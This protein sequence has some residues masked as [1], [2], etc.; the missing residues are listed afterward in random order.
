MERTHGQL[1]TR[2]TNGLRSHDADGLGHDLADWNANT[3]AGATVLFANDD[4]LGHVH[5]TTGEVAG[6]SGTQRSIGQTLTGTV[7]VIEVLQHGQAFTEGG[8]NRTGDVITVRVHNHALHTG[9]R[10]DLTHVTGSTKLHNQKTVLIL[11]ST[12]CPSPNSHSPH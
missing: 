8:L 9:Q 10:P 12:V 2:L 3:L 7:G 4:V 11:A 6:I 5:Q 1:G